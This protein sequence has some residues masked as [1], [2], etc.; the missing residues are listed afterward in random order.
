MN[1]NLGAYYNVIRPDSAPSW[2]IRFQLVF[3]FPR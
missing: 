2:Q 3:L 1:A